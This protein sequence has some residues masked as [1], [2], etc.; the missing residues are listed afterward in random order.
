MSRPNCGKTSRRSGLALALHPM[1][2]I[3]HF[4]A[5]GNGHSIFDGDT[6]IS[7]FTAFRTRFGTML[8]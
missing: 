6:D 2:P 5:F 3:A 1:R 8:P 7:D 4:L